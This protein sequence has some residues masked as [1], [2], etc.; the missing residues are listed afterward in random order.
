MEKHMINGL[1]KEKM[2]IDYIFLKKRK[3][4]TQK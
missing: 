3:E 4:T 2:G 1:K